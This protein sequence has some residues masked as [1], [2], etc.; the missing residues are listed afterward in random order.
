MNDVIHL[1]QPTQWIEGRDQEDEVTTLSQHHHYSTMIINFKETT[2][3][4]ISL[5][6]NN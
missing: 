2:L 1:N 5:D 3:P 4:I 6:T